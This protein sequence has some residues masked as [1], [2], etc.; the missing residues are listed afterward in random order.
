MPLL[1]PAVYKHHLAIWCSLLKEKALRHCL[2]TTCYI[3]NKK[4]N[5]AFVRVRFNYF[6]LLHLIFYS[7]SGLKSLYGKSEPGHCIASQGRFRRYVAS[8]KT[9]KRA[10]IYFMRHGNNVR[11]FT[12]PFSFT[13]H[14]LRS[15]VGVNRKVV[16]CLF[17]NGWKKITADL[18]QSFYDT[19]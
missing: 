3:R 16:Y 19:F 13:L 14:L 5:T 17:T 8:P 11:Q 12:F 6:F 7:V 15:S 4:V 9:A 18:I 10:L 2:H 1:Y